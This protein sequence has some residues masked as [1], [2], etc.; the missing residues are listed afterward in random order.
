M[1]VGSPVW[2]SPQSQHTGSPLPGNVQGFIPVTASPIVGG[3]NVGSTQVFVLEP[4]PG[5]PQHN[6]NAFDD[7]R[8]ENGDIKSTIVDSSAPANQTFGYPSF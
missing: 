2:G 5:S 1:P 4:A 6:T 3:Y 7:A 8:T